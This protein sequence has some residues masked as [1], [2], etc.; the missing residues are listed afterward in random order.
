MVAGETKCGTQREMCCTVTLFRPRREREGPR[1]AR[2]IPSTRRRDRGGEC[3]ARE[4][5][6]RSCRILPSSVPS[7]PMLHRASI[8]HTPLLPV[9]RVVKRATALGAMQDRQSPREP[10]RPRPRLQQSPQRVLELA[11]LSLQP[12][13]GNCRRCLRIRVGSCVLVHPVAS[14]PQRLA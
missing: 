4:R 14:Q 9:A 3:T 5:L 12:C 1:L 7:P 10:Q 8:A 6:A 11:R 2:L 13:F